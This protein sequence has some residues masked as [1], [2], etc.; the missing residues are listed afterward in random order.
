MSRRYHHR[1]SAISCEDR[2]SPFCVS[3]NL[4]FQSDER[5]NQASKENPWSRMPGGSSRE[6]RT[7]GTT[8]GPFDFCLAPQ[9]GPASTRR[10]GCLAR[11]QTSRSRH[12]RRRGGSVSLD[13][14]HTAPESPL[15]F[16]PEIVKLTMQD[17]ARLLDETASLK[18]QLRSSHERDPGV[19][20]SPRAGPGTAP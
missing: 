12:R 10:T 2:G 11:E 1:V 16:E 14:E 15:A 8:R 19:P 13:Q 20:R 18:L 7:S 4:T 6:D 5:H 17:N 3:T 9:R